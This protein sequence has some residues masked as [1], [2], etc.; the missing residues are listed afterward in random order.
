MPKGRKSSCVVRV[1]ETLMDSVEKR[2]TFRDMNRT[3]I[4]NYALRQLDK[5]LAADLNRSWAVALVSAVARAAGARDVI[6][7]IGTSVDEDGRV[8]HSL[9][10]MIDGRMVHDLPVLKD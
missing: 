7:T 2:P 8:K 5:G 3:E 1:N 4:A 6:V 9:G 10:A